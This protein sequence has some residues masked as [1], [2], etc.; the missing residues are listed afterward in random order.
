MRKRSTRGF[1]FIELLMA[2]SIVGVLSIAGVSGF[3][4]S[5]VTQREKE[6]R[7]FM[8]TVED[9]LVSY[10][11]VNGTFNKDAFVKW[12]GYRKKLENYNVNGMEFV[13]TANGPNPGDY[14]TLP[15]K[16]VTR[17]D[18][19]VTE[20]DAGGYFRKR[21]ELITSF[22]LKKLLLLEAAM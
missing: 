8:A 10:M 15:S 1:T 5:L 17:A 20:F 7:M 19:L 2:V 4:R 11:Q 12:A 22:K 18:D 3:G 6:G 13:I 14:F 9:L 21:F 16:D